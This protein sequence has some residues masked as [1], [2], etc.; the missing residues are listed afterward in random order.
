MTEWV[1][2]CIC[3]K[4]CI[5]F[6]HSSVEIIQMTQKAFRD[7]AMSAAHIKVWHKCFKDGWQSVES[8]PHSGNPATNRT[9]ENIERI[10]AAISKDRQL[11]VWDL[12][13]DMRIPKTTVSKILMQDRVVVNFTP[14]L[15]LPE[16]K[17]HRAAA[18]RT[19]WGP[20]CLLWRGLR[21]PYLMYNV[22]CVIFNE[23]LYFSYYM[24]GYFLNR[25]HIW[26]HSGFA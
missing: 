26:R 2:Q 14:W 11:T 19:V 8:D 17:E 15:L 21:C 6:E 13:A 5:N 16:Q 12:E 3:I 10:W 9:P 1:E 25:L 23:C 7:N 4:L 24:A 22:S 18:G 20:R